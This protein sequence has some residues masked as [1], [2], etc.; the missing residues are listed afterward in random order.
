MFF[1][2]SL[3]TQKINPANWDNER[4]TKW[5]TILFR[6]FFLY[7]L[8]CACCRKLFLY[9]FHVYMHSFFIF[10]VLLIVSPFCKQTDMHD[11]Y[12][13]ISRLKIWQIT[14]E[15]MT[16]QNLRSFSTE[17]KRE[18]TNEKENH[19][20]RK[21]SDSNLLNEQIVTTE[22][23]NLMV[24]HDDSHCGLRILQVYS[25]T[26]NIVTPLPGKQIL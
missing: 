25:W 5:W 20:R 22:I 9:V 6:S 23:L 10:L 24:I 11:G 18:T 21:K 26:Y 17:L 13:C 4:S 15:K 16:E 19:S 12:H 14:R 8:L 2:C 1:V 3:L 7:A